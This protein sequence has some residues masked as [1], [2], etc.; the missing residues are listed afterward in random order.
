MKKHIKTYIKDNLAAKIYRSLEKKYL[1][2]ESSF[3]IKQIINNFKNLEEKLY[4][5][6][7]LKLLRYKQY[8]YYLTKQKNIVINEQKKKKSFSNILTINKKNDG[9]IYTNT[10]N[11]KAIVHI[12]ST[13]HNTII[14]ATNKN[15][16]VILWRSGGSLGFK[17][18][19]KG[20]FYVGETIGKLFGIQLL[21]KGLNPIKIK[22]KGFG[23]GRRAAIRGLKR[24]RILINKIVDITPIPHNGCRAPKRRRK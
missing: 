7:K 2:G 1:I 11:Y 17:G 21:K 24:T 23:Q 10:I 19:K 9:I 22:I 18:S 14:T 8:K 20:S 12:L 15:G 3:K 13:K 6:V 5:L 4:N 16:D